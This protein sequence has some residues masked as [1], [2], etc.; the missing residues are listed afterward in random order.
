M[1]PKRVTGLQRQV[2]HL[3]KRALQMVATKPIANVAA[4][5]HLLRRGSKMVDQYGQP[6]VTAISLPEG[7]ESYP[8]GWVARGGKERST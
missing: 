2:L 3:Y 1:P 5:E 6:S 8:L 7:A 4:I